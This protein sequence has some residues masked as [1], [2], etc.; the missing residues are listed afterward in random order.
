MTGVLKTGLYNY[1]I[2][3]NRYI[4]IQQ[5]DVASNGTYSFGS[6]SNLAHVVFLVLIGTW[7]Y[8]DTILIKA[9]NGS[10]PKTTHLINTASE[11]TYP[12]TANGAW[13]FSIKN[14]TSISQ[15]ALLIIMN[16]YG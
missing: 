5:F 1:L 14:T 12:V 13:G 7:N 2:N 3:M 15:K 8:Q 9:Q 11:T 6:N 4:G 16:P 10:T